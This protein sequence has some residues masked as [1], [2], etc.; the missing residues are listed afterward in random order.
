MIVNNNL[1]LI[2]EKDLV[3]MHY[4]HNT[5]QILMLGK[6]GQI[7][8]VSVPKETSSDGMKRSIRLPER[9]ENIKEQTQETDS[10]TEKWWDKTQ[11]R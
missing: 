10:K 7:N 6:D 3:N 1:Q 2:A 11:S 4:N 5:Q 8:R 9:K